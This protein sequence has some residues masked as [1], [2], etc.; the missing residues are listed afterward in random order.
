MSRVPPI[1]KS[2]QDDLWKK[3]PEDIQTVGKTTA[4]RL[5]RVNTAVSRRAGSEFVDGIRDL[6]KAE[7]DLAILRRRMM[8][9]LYSG[10]ATPRQIADEMGKHGCPMDHQTAYRWVT[11][12]VEEAGWT[13]DAI[14]ETPKH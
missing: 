7:E 4:R 13:M 12:A 1:K 9:L 2:F 8:L 11:R 10:G 14:R 5:G 3:I 6:M